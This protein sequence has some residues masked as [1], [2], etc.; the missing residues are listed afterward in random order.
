MGK[1]SVSGETFKSVVPCWRSWNKLVCQSQTSET[2]L[3]FFRM[4]SA[5]NATNLQPLPIICQIALTPPSQHY[6]QSFR[7]KY[8]GL[9]VLERHRSLI[10]ETLLAFFLQLRL[11]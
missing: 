8:E 4:A 5:G 3:C 6:Q 7:C 9:P 1:S 2:Q 11:H 10:G